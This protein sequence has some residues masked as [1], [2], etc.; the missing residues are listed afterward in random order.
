[1]TMEKQP[2][3]DVSPIKNGDFPAIA[4]LNVSLLEGISSDIPATISTCPSNPQK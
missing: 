1:M 4:M 2:V 3:E